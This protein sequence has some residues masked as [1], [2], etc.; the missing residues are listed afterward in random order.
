MLTFH[1]AFKLILY[2]DLVVQTLNYMFSFIDL[3]NFVS[4]FNQELW[5]SINFSHQ[6][7]H[8]RS[9][10]ASAVLCEIYLH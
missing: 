9:F 10:N 7:L 3:S 6:F 2:F 1:A 4:F 5:F 8:T